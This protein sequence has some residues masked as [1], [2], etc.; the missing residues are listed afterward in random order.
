MLVKITRKRGLRTSAIA[1]VVA[2]PSEEPADDCQTRMDEAVQ[3][4]RSE[5]ATPERLL[6]LEKA[7]HAASAES[8]RRILERE[9]NRLEPK[10]KHALPNKVRFHRET[11][12]INKRTPARVA[13]RFGTITVWSYYYLNETEGEPGLH[14]LWL[15]LGIPCGC[16]WASVRVRRRQR[17]W[18]ASRA[19][20][21][22]IAKA[23]CGPGCCA[24]TA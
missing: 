23:R 19:W 4:F 21:W 13:T 14:P 7:L 1:T 20:R 12:R 5:P 6:G 16:A 11:Y 3:R 2:T 24:S 15:R 10:E 17:C 18:N 8:C 9:V 22:I